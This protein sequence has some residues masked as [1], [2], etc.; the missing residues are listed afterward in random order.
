[1][2]SRACTPTS[3]TSAS[4]SR[5]ASKNQQVQ[6]PQRLRRPPPH[7]SNPSTCVVDTKEL[8]DPEQGGDKLK[9]VAGNDKQLDT[10]RAEI[11]D[12]KFSLE[13]VIRRAELAQEAKA[14][15]EHQLREDIR[16]KHP[17]RR[18]A[19]SLDS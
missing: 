19:M 4:A 16:N 7:E 8:L 2:I 15:L 18:R 6:K 17:S 3:R 1:M 13:E 12:L 9:L 11:S 10:A 5:N 14:A